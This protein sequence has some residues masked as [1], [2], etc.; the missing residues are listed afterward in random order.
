M[1]L[2][3]IWKRC[4]TRGTTHSSL[5]TIQSFKAERYEQILARRAEGISQNLHRSLTR[6]KRLVSEDVTAALIEHVR[7]SI[8]YERQHLR[9]LEAL[10]PDVQN[11]D[12]KHIPTK[13]TTAPRPSY[14]PPLEDF[15]KPV[16]PPM[17]SAPVSNIN[18]APSTTPSLSGPLSA[19]PAS[20]SPATTPQR[21][22]PAL[23]SSV[24]NSPL[25]SPGAGPSSPTP[26]SAKPLAP[27]P[28]PLLDGPPLGGRLVDGTKSMFVKHTPSPLSPA[29]GP[30][31]PNRIQSPL[32]STS[33]NS[34]AP[35]PLAQ[36]TS[37]VESPLH[38][39]SSG[40]QNGRADDLDPLGMAK[41]SFM[42]QSVRVQPTRPRLDAREA[43]SKLANMF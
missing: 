25:Q 42:S 2:L 29:S 12:K 40:P 19:R 23:P 9:E 32:H 1:R 3:K 30:G 21:Y 26:H 17:N 34:S 13:P 11:A 31:V 28:A 4:D 33:F 14:I 7:S 15:S 41:P 36:S 16:P 22:T 27:A 10:R 18:R 39:A 38:S 6:H 20:P 5:L 35:H 24:V 8:M 43:A 37:A